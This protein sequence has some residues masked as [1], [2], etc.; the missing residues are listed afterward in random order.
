MPKI[1]IIT[2]V[3]DHE[4]GL[5]RTFKSIQGQ[6]F[7]DWEMIIVV[8]KSKDKTLEVALAFQEIESRVR[9]LEQEGFGI[10]SAMN[11]GLAITTGE[12][13][14]FMNAGDKF[15]A[16]SVLQKALECIG[17]SQAGLLIGSYG[18]ESCTVTTIYPNKNKGVS[19]YSFAFNRRSGCHQSMLFRSNTIRKL[20]GFDTSYLLA[21]DFDLVLSRCQILLALIP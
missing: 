2:V 18:V 20:G 5:S 9:V 11:Q 15:Y 6:E 21:S 12:Y 8:G 16:N 1:S 13:T 10:Y 3:K 7:Q 17:A 14:W 19:A 4:A